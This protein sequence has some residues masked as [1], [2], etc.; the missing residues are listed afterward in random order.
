MSS[1]GKTFKELFERPAM[2]TEGLH[3]KTFEQVF[4]NGRL[5]RAIA[6]VVGKPGSLRF[7]LARG[8]STIDRWPKIL[9]HLDW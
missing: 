7:R 2:T 9:G 8:T 6:R 1:K 3:E 4:S 5:D